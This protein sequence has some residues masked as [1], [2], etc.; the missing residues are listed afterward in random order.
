[1][2]NQLAQN[3]WAVAVRG[4]AAVIFGILALIWPGITFTVLVFFWGAYA[5]VD[6]IFAIVTM[7]THH[8]EGNPRWMLLLE[9]LAGILAGVLTFIWPAITGL[10]LLYLIAAWAVVTGVL[11]IIAAVRLRREIANEWM[12]ALAGATSL[13]FGI[14]VALFPAA[15]ALAVVWL[16]G[17]YAV[18]FGLLLLFLAIRLRSYAGGRIRPPMTG[19]PA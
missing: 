14:V 17:T 2:L 1:M 11:E 3:W 16:I 7:L 6:G 18:V 13:V 10:V 5:L 15:G 12:L 19:A 8:T 9:G 4:L